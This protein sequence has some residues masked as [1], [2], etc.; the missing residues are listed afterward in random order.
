MAKKSKT[1]IF[2]TRCRRC[3]SINGWIF[4]PNHNKPTEKEKAFHISYHQ[5]YP[6]SV[7]FCE[8]CNEK[9]RQEWVCLTNK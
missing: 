1:W 9:T 6:F 8:T 2:E 7:V 4:N 3:D 5:E